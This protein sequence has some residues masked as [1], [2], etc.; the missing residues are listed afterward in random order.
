MIKN[1]VVEDQTENRYNIRA[2]DRAFHILALLSDG[3]P[4]TLQELSG[5]I[6][7]STST[8]FRQL[9]TLVQYR[10]VQRDEQTSNTHSFCP[11][12][13]LRALTTKK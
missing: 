12:W 7:L 6:D 11:A 5:E 10:Y 2:L 3:K 9:A 4:R 1:P 8:T 13:N